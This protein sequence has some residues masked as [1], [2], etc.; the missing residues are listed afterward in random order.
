MPFLEH[1][2]CRILTRTVCSV[3]VGH[4]VLGGGGGGGGNLRRLGPFLGF[5]ILNFIIFW[6]FPKNE[7]FGGMNIL[8]IFFGSSQYWTISRGH[9]YEYYGL[10]LWLMYRMGDIFWGW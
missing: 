8:W 3:M 2:S 10:F 7:Y 4:V 6:G 5:K 9:F 1:K